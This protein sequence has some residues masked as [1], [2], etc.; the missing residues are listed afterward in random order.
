[1]DNDPLQYQMDSGW[2]DREQQQQQHEE[3]VNVYHQRSIRCTLDPSGRKMWAVISLGPQLLFDILLFV[4]MWR[5]CEEVHKQTKIKMTRRAAQNICQNVARTIIP[6]T[7]TLAI[8][9]TISS[10]FVEK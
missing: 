8:S 1:M 2:T 9:S 6:Y 10:E 4:G 3:H 5:H 7:A